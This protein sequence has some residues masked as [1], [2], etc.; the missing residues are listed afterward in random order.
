MIANLIKKISKLKTDINKAKVESIK[1]DYTLL[2]ENKK[3]RKLKYELKEDQNIIRNSYILFILGLLGLVASTGL[4]LAGGINHYKDFNK[5]AFVIAMIFIQVAIFVV[6]AYESVIKYRFSQHYVL[7]K[8]CQVLLLATS[9]KFNFDFFDEKS[10]FTFF[11]C[12]IL[13]CITIKFISLS[14]DFRHLISRN[15][16]KIT[17]DSFIDLLKMWI[18]NKLY[19]TKS[20]I[21]STYELNNKFKEIEETETIRIEEIEPE[22]KQIE[23][24]IEKKEFVELDL[25]VDEE[26]TNYQYIKKPLDIDNIRKYHEFVLANLKDGN[27]IPGIKKV[28]ENLGLT[29]GESMRIYNKLRDKAYIKTLEDR[30]TRLQKK[31]FI[32]SD[33]LEV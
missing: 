31:D 14:Y 9:I 2:I 26:T 17:N 23:A 13:D 32:E 10:I 6:S 33:F 16:R 21:I 28:A 7:V 3:A 27:V 5:Y 29:Q 18:D 24:S 22:V 4:S 11:M 15:N 25:V 8:L 12:V 20:Q 19:K 1:N 30:K